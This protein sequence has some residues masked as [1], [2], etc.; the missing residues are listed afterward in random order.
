MSINNLLD[1]HNL[2]VKEKVEDNVRSLLE[3]FQKEI[4]LEIDKRG[5]S[6]NKEQI[7]STFQN[8]SSQ[9]QLIKLNSDDNDNLPMR[10]QGKQ[11]KPI[12]INL[13]KEIRRKTTRVKGKKHFSNLKAYC[14]I[15]ESSDDDIDENDDNNVDN[16]DNADNVDNT[17]K[18]CINSQD[19][20]VI[21][22]QQ[23]KIKD[24]DIIEVYF[25]KENKLVNN[26]DQNSL[27][28]KYYLDI[29][30]KFVF[31]YEDRIAVGILKDNV[32][33]TNI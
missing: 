18:S 11:N 14:H 2:L 25:N 30:S 32:L 15:V 23:I 33:S 13:D 9:Q 5:G 7:Q 12:A 29:K 24:R 19:G 31:G 8:F 21:E 3:E 27:D 17:N 4:L 28:T 26:G 1:R 10:F 6:L 20:E 22:I 16:A